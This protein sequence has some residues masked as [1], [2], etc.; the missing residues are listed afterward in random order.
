MVFR[1]VFG[2]ELLV[3]SEPLRLPGS[4][5]DVVAWGVAEPVLLCVSVTDVFTRVVRSAT[6]VAF[7]ES[8]DCCNGAVDTTLHPASE[9]VARHSVGVGSIRLHPV[10]PGVA[11][12]VARLGSTA[13]QPW[14]V[15]D[16]TQSASAGST[17]L[18]PATVG[19]AVH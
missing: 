9:G 11:I 2:A 16:F 18:H 17:A 3:V 6:V 10:A 4:P 19:V 5:P 13:L 12:H 14:S 7:T 15:G 1:S 8:T